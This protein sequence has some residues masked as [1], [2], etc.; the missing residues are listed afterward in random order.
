MSQHRC[1]QGEH[2]GR[3]TG[4]GGAPRKI[5]LADA[6][7]LSR[8]G[9]LREEAREAYAAAGLKG[10]WMGYFASRAAA[11]GPVPANVVVATFYNF[12]LAMVARAIPDAWHFSSPERIL[13]ARYRVADS[14]L[15][16]LLGEDR[17][18]SP[19]ILE[20]AD[21]ARR[22]AESCSP[23][24]RP[25]FAAHSSLPWPD[26]PHLALWHA[27][28]LLREYRGDGHVAALLSSGVDG[29]EAHITLAGTGV[30]SRE[31]LQPYR[32]WSDAA[33]ESAQ[34]RLVRRG[35]LDSQGHLT[36]AGQRGRQ[37]IERLTDELAA[38]PWEHLGEVNSRRLVELMWP[39]SDTIVSQGGF[40]IPNPMGLRWP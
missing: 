25:L 37:A 15:H 17:L 24:G 36:E 4:R 26:S 35:W 13:A 39:I 28:T 9:L 2:N 31:S 32:G 6:G 38:A 10:F 14:A 34:Q 19:D 8:H 30:V 22:A 33:W 27:V 1:G 12:D 3:R 5:S 11:L 7:T 16:R 29:C 21:L 40:S 23:A 20:S 18:T